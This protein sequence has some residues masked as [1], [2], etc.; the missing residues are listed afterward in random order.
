M[1]TLD[2]DGL[3]AQKAT[4]PDWI[5]NRS[6]THVILGVPESPESFKTIV[7]PGN[8][9]SPG[10]RSYSV[11]TWVTV[12]GRVFAPEELDLTELRWRYVDGYIPVL[13][14]TWRAG[15]IEVRS[16]VFTDGDPQRRD[17]RTN[18]E[19][20]VANLADHQKV[21][22][23]HFVIRSF[24]PAGAPIT[25]ISVGGRDVSVNGQI[26]L[27]V[28]RVPDRV[29]LVSYAETRSDIG[30]VLRS[31]G[32]AL[33]ESVSDPTGWASGSLDYRIRLEPGAVETRS[34]TSF[35]H[36]NDPLLTWMHRPGGLPFESV[37]RDA[38]I[39]KW[40]QLVPM[41]LDLPDRRYG[42]AMKAQ[43]A[44]L[45][46]STV[47]SQP[48]ISPISYP[49]WWLRD[50]AYVLTAMEKGGLGEWVDRAVRQVAPR[51][52]FGGFGAEGDGAAHIIWLISEHFLMTGDEEFLREFYPEIERNVAIIIDMLEAVEPIFG[53]TEIRTPEMMFAPQADLMC[54]PASDGLIVGRMD[55]HFPI[56]WINGWAHFALGRAAMCSTA[57][58]RDNA[59]TV[60]RQAELLRALDRYKL[61]HFGENDRDLGSCLWPTGWAKAD[62]PVIRAG[63]EKFW[64][65]TRF[66]EG[67]YY[68]EP[69]WT[70]FEAAQAHN[71]AF[72]GERDKSWVTFEMFLTT[73]TAPGLF[74]SFEGTGDENSSLQWQRTRGWDNI[75][76]VTPHGW[77]AAELFLALRDGLLR[78]TPDGQLIIGTAVPNHWMES[79]FSARKL[80]SHFGLVDIEYIAATR[81][82][83]VHVERGAPRIVS[84]LPGDV[85]IV[86]TGMHR[87]GAL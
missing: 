37:D 23:L 27:S 82:L 5:W 30:N 39:H 54:A 65:E 24:G 77:T 61:A 83:R 63:F 7:E 11:S 35:V 2:H 10:F 49:L 15:A 29:Q 16:S 3:V 72:L 60:K 36:A 13:E 57:L 81:E 64:A 17:I 79:N 34:L 73:H 56:I 22:D 43:I 85:T 51:P 4:H 59:N 42:E 45:T 55:L 26:A 48:R 71:Y 68:A 86:A 50:G 58:G 41:V 6:D 32:S 25:A 9:F 38:F 67:S 8:S 84:E 62:D 78:E 75:R 76:F 52:P 53:G 14:S 31:G 87:G 12:D 66:R 33:G 44:Y 80:P 47:G 46:M 18:L 70:Y 69:E 40:E 1:T 74:T 21:I 28:D 19:A 20:T